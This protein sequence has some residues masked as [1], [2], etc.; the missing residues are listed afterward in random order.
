MVTN[1]LTY[2]SVSTNNDARHID[3]DPADLMLVVGADA[4]FAVGW[5]IRSHPE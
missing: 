1:L 4:R 2:S 5:K 3:D